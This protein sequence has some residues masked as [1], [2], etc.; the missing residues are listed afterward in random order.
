MS[1]RHGQGV[2]GFDQYRGIYLKRIPTYSFPLMLEIM[3]ELGVAPTSVLNNTGLDLATVSREETRVSFLQ[4]L[5]FVRNL[6]KH[7]PR[8]DIGLHIGDRYHISTYGVLG[9]AMMSCTTWADA[10]RLA[11]RFHRVA[12][13][14][15][16]IELD[17][18]SKRQTLTYVA[19]PFYPD[20]DDIEPFTVE[21]LFASLIAVSKPVLPEPAYP[22]RVSFTHP[23]PRYAAAYEAIFP[24]P[25]EFGARE[26]R[27]EVD[28]ARLQQPLL[29]ANEVCA[30]MGRRMCEEHLSQYEQADDSIRRKVTD[31][32]L[33]APSG[34]PGMDSVAEK[35]HMSSRTLRRLLQ[36]ENCTFQDI[37]DELRHDLSKKYLRSSHLNLDEIAHLVGFT[38]STNFRRAFKRWQG[39]PPARYRR[40]VQAPGR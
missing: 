17:I 40:Q 28:M 10:L 22:S 39:V 29:A 24:C 19:T 27:F 31:Q 35:L 32:L 11:G 12:S 16:A 37:C 30:A 15:V 14:L 33:A 38:E 1:A 6:L 21:K 4:A 23:R 20:L 2:A 7:S 26:N 3:Q 8:A 18:D 34:M 13:S 36:A 25:V 5:K 9:Y